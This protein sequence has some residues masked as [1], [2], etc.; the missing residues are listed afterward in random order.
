M[1]SSRPSLVLTLTPEPYEPP[2]KKQT[3]GGSGSL[4]PARVIWTWKKPSP[5]GRRT[6]DSA[7][8]ATRT[9]A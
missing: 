2:C 6:G 9:S 3:H 1:F 8:R 7:A 5:G 4:V